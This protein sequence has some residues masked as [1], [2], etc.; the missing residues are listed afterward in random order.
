MSPEL[1]FEFS[2]ETWTK[3]PKFC[4]KHFGTLKSVVTAHV[5]IAISPCHLK[6]TDQVSHGKN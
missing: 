3:L 2:D 4:K 5:Q 1:C 6:F